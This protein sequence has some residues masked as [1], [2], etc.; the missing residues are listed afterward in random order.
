MD[1]ALTIFHT[2]S[3][4]F[5]APVEAFSISSVYSYLIYEYSG[6]TI[7]RDGMPSNDRYGRLKNLT[8][9]SKSCRSTGS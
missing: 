7:L 5:A 2:V 3:I 6:Y 4:S 8:S 9:D 1:V